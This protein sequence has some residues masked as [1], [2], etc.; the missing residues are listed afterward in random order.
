MLKG[1]ETT[2]R[3][4]NARTPDLNALKQEINIVFK[5]PEEGTLHAL[6]FADL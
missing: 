2:T 5:V 4:L 3:I 1:L 6:I